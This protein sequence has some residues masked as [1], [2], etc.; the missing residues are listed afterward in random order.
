M[1]RIEN[2]WELLRPY[3][4]R[5]KPKKYTQL[6]QESRNSSIKT[7]QEQPERKSS[8]N[9][10]S[11]IK[12]KSLK[13]SQIQA[14]SKNESAQKAISPFKQTESHG[15]GRR[16]ARNFGKESET[17]DTGVID[18]KNKE[19]NNEKRGSIIDFYEKE[20]LV[21]QRIEN[22]NVNYSLASELIRK[23]G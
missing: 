23:N 13:P 22:K 18:G 21:Q 10:R 7:S 14:K 3:R 20:C 4:E 2:L 15:R 9:P 11:F 16:N 5:P 19:E 17:A 12:E 8:F 1:T 6:L